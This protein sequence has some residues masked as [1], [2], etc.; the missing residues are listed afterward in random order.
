[1]SKLSP[2]GRAQIIEMYCTRKK[3]SSPL[4]LPHKRGVSQRE[5]GFLTTVALEQWPL[6]EGHLAVRRAG[7][8]TAVRRGCTKKRFAERRAG[9]SYSAR[10]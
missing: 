7:E 5:K 2:G 9:V 1:L 3:V 10:Q 8:Y 4:T 6:S